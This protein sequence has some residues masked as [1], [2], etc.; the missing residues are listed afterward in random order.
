MENLLEKIYKIHSQTP[1]QIFFGVNDENII[2]LEQSFN[3]RLVARGNTIKILGKQEEI[4]VI[5]NILEDL[6]S[7]LQKK[8]S[9]SPQDVAT[10]IQVFK[11]QISYSENKSVNGTADP[12]EISIQTISKLIRPKSENQE[13][14]IR[15]I[16]KNDLVFAIGPA[17]TGKTYLAVAQAA[18]LLKDGVV[19]KLVL[20]RPA[21]E[22]GESLGF[23]PGDFK[24]KIDPYLKPLYDALAEM[25]P[26]EQLKKYFDYDTI[27]VLPLAYMRGRTLNNAFVILDEAQNSTFVQ[28]KMFLTRLGQN[29]K[30]VVTG[31]ITQV[32]LDPSKESGL[33][34][35][36]EVLKD[37]KKIDFVRLTE[38]DVVRHPLVKDIIEA[39]D[40]FAKKNTSRK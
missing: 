9:L 6:E 19:K 5:F 32:D 22:A 24:E 18:K 35:S 34:T 10:T 16:S 25:I 31:D 36:I 4:D 38:A 23:L 30:A 8:K 15:S 2:L 17:G 39:Y 14:L 12:V 27:E 7:T 26:R 28:M 20:S 21:V 11:N 13:K 37:V 1:I 29:S 40:K 33:I 3:S